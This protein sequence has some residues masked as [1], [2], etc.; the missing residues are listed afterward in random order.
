MKSDEMNGMISNVLR[1][2]V[3]LSSA[4]VAVGAA[5]FLARYSSADSASLLAYCRSCVPHGDF[6][7]DPARILAGLLSLDPFSV[8]EVG[9]LVLLATPVVRV[10]MSVLIFAAEKDRAYV[11]VTLAV[12]LLLLFSILVTPFIPLFHA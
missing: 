1:Y 2:G 3:V 7:V 4:I 8:I 5:L 6:S 11:V 12:L 9:I 10:A